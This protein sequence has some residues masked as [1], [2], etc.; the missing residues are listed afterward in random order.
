MIIRQKADVS[1]SL[2]SFSIESHTCK[3]GHF[4]ISHWSQSCKFGQILC[5]PSTWSHFFSWWLHISVQ[6]SVSVDLWRKGEKSVE[7][8]ASSWILC[9]QVRLGIEE[10]LLKIAHVH[11]KGER[12]VRSQAQ[13]S[14]QCGL[15]FLFWFLPALWHLAYFLNFW[16]TPFSSL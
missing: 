7:R 13:G 14:G 15:G 11:L 10:D 16:K 4:R 5:T 12:E 2:W 9:I 1:S 6:T 8:L 3:L